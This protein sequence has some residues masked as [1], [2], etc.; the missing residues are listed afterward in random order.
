MKLNIA[1]V[2]G[3]GKSSLCNILENEGYS[4]FREPVFDNPLLDK[5]YYNKERYSFPLQIFFL[6]KRFEMCK[7]ANEIERSVL[8]RSILEDAIFAKMLRDRSEMDPYEYQ[9]YR[10]LLSNMMV[11]IRPP[12]L[13][14]YLKVSPKEAIRRIKKRGRDYEV[15]N[16]TDYWYDLNQNYNNFF[17]EYKWSPLLTINVDELDFVNRET[18]AKYVL[19]LIGNELY[20]KTK[21]V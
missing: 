1:G 7:Q 13:M 6:N 14:V 3:V 21:M 4:I 12:E 15:K 2:V 20:G 17:H 18:D 11:H 16:D 19:D 10:E 8:D 9:I 5:F